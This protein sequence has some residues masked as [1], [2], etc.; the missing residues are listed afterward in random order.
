MLDE[1]IPPYSASIW[2]FQKE[3]GLGNLIVASPET[4]TA[5]LLPRTTGKFT[6]KGLIVNGLRYGSD[7]FAERFLKGNKVN[8]AFNPD[9]V[10]CVYLVDENFKRFELIDTQFNGAKL[11]SVNQTKTEQKE[12]TKHFYEESMQGRIDLIS[13]IQTIVEQ[14]AITPKK[15]LK[16]IGENRRIEKYETHKDIITEVKNDD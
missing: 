1:K 9:N 5:L 8:I 14:G 15:S 6:R 16:S 2:R 3:H 4:I 10:S 13:H 11:D 12:H 7:G